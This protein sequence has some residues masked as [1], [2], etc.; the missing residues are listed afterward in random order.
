[1]PTSPPL[2]LTALLQSP[3]LSYVRSVSGKILYISPQCHRIF[4]QVAESIQGRFLSDLLVANNLN[5]QRWDA[6]EASTAQGNVEHHLELEVI[7]GTE[8]TRWVELQ[9]SFFIDTSSTPP[10][11]RIAGSMIDIT[12]RRLR[13]TQLLDAQRLENLGLLS[14]G[15]AHDLITSSPPSSSPTPCLIPWRW[16]HAKNAWSKSCSLPP[17]AVPASCVKFSALP[18][19]VRPTVVPSTLAT[20]CTNSSSSFR[21]RSPAT[22]PSPTTSRANFT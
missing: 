5:H 4:G 1:M 2:A 11:E 9:E 17:N 8:N 3:A 12:A 16:S 14:A 19:G 13:E 7:S 22:S 15:I 20:C 10:T 6:H 21:K 18:M